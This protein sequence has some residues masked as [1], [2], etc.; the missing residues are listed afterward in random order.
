MTTGL[1]V[2]ATHR[3]VEFVEPLCESVRR[4]FHTTERTQ[5][6]LFT[7]GP[8]A[9]EGVWRVHQP[10]LPWPQTTLLRYNMYLEQEA[11]LSGLDYLFCCDAD[12]RLVDH[13]GPEILGDRV[14]TLHPG[15]FQVPRRRFPYETRPNSR[16]YVGPDEGHWYFAGGFNG[17]RAAAFLDTARAVRDMVDEDRSRDL[18]AVWHDE[19]YLNRVFCD[20]APSLILSPSYCHPESMTLPLPRKLVALDKPHAELRR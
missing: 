5:V 6:I 8:Q 11:L 20:N 1:L 12:M 14:A 18:I 2:V 10:H 15:F 9:P 19:S 17:A 4:Y 16:A 3:Y 7:D 13:V